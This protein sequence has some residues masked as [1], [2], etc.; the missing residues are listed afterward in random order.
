METDESDKKSEET[1]LTTAALGQRW[2]GQ[3]DN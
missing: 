3:A 1:G 2:N